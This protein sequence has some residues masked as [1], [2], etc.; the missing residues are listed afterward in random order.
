MKGKILSFVLILSAALFAALICG[1]MAFADD[2]AGANDVGVLLIALYA[3]IGAV[4]LVLLNLYWDIFK[5]K[6][7]AIWAVKED[8]FR[9]KLRGTLIAAVVNVWDTLKE[10]YK[11]G[12]LDAIIALIIKIIRAKF[13]IPTALRNVSAAFNRDSERPR[14]L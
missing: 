1:G 2:G 5:P 6:L 14:R 12:L 8:S 4:V 9:W 13:G 7:A 3:A 11:R 10:S